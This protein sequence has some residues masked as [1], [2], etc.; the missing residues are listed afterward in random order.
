V[1]RAPVVMVEHTTAL[2]VRWGDVD[3]AGIVFYPRFF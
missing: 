1:G 3:A 2:P